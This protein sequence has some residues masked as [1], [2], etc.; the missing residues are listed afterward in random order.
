MKI[1]I[2][3]YNPQDYGIKYLQEGG[4][5]PVEAPVEEGA[6]VEQQAGGDPMQE[7]LTA[8][9]QAVQSQDCNLAMQV[10]QALMQMAGGGGEA[11]V[12]EGTEPVYRMGG[13]LAYFKKK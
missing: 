7:L 3:N 8:C 4:E 12:P 11:P 2:K 1:N 9:Q 5:M 13:R 10:C 6:P